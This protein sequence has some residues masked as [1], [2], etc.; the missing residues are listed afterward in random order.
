MN[1]DGDPDLITIIISPL[2]SLMVDQVTHRQE[3]G[4]DTAF[5]GE[6]QT[7]HYVKDNVSNAKYSV[8]CL[9]PESGVDSN[10]RIVLSS[11]VH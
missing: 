8:L 7:D 2:S 4:L 6:L 9:T 1:K 5:V 3:M 10:W 11:D